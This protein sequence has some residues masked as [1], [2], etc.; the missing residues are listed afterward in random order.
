MILP[1]SVIIF[2]E[3]FIFL[4]IMLVIIKHKPDNILGSFRRNFDHFI[5][6]TAQTIAQSTTT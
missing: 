2:V 6:S 5:G 1:K 4:F 3:K